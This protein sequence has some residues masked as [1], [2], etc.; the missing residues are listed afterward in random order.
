MMRAG[1]ICFGTGFSLSPVIHGHWIARHG[2]DGHYDRYDLAP[3]DLPH[4]LD[5]IR[6]GQLV[7]V[8]VT[9]PHK[10]SVMVFLDDMSDAARACGAANIV[11]RLSDGRLWGDNS[12]GMGFLAHLRQTHHDIDLSKP[13]ALLGA[14]GAARGILYGL[15]ASVAH[16]GELRISNRNGARAAALIADLQPLAMAHG[17]RLVA[18]DWAER[19]QML[20]QAGLLVNATALGM[21][22]QPPLDLSLEFLPQKAAVYDIVYKPLETDLLRRARLRG[23]LVIDGLGML[24][25]QAVPAF[26]RFFGQAVEV[27]QDLRLAALRA[28]EAHGAL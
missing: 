24:L 19:A 20:D 1:V 11:A 18:W 4:F 8:N 15:I 28:L 6:A 12:D 23:H 7:G 5:N 21:A 22:G 9:I 3:S 10:E 2:L 25:H 13:I 14:G 27:D 26:E 16:L 17:T